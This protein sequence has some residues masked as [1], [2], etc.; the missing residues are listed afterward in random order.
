MT[1]ARIA[2]RGYQNSM[3]HF[4]PIPSDTARLSRVERDRLRLAASAFANAYAALRQRS[5]IA[6]NGGWGL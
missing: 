4:A 3:M 2:E 1:F 6:Y 5:S